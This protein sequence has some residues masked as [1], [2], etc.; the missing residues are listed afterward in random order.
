MAEYCDDGRFAIRRTVWEEQNFYRSVA[1]KQYGA[2]YDISSRFQNYFEQYGCTLALCNNS[3]ID[4]LISFGYSKSNIYISLHDSGWTSEIDTAISKGIKHFY[5]DEP[6]Q[7]SRQDLVRDVSYYLSTRGC[8]LTISESYFNYFNWY[9][10]HGRGRIGDMIDL[11]LSI[12]PHPFVSCHTHFEHHSLGTLDPRDQWTYIKNRVSSLFRYAWIKTR[13]TS[14]EIDLLFGHA[15]NLGLKK[16]FLYLYDSDGTTYLNKVNVAAEQGWHSGW[17]QR[18][19]KEREDKWCCPTQLYDPDECT[20]E[21]KHYT[22][23]ER[24]V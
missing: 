15:T 23:V 22:G 5:I 2:G 17:V 8:D 10:L 16:I 14:N 21:S 18:F 19:E 3:L 1:N 13:Q 4:N 20:L 7:K 24:W 6:I 11:S 9:I 12:T